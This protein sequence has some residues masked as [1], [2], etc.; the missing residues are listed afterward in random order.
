MRESGVWTLFLALERD[1]P[2]L[3]IM[4]IWIFIGKYWGDIV[5]VIGL[6]LTIWVG[7]QAKSAAKAAKEASET[8]REEVRQE[9]SR[10]DLERAGALIQ[11]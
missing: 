1:S 9:L 10:I 4:N 5:T 3:L 11:R 6:A 7:F 8:A 2:S